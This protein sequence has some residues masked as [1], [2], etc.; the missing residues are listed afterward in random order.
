MSD[1]SDLFP[2]GPWTGFYQHGG[3]RYRQDL[4]LTFENGGL[5]GI[6]SDIVG[7][8]VVRGR[9]CRESLEVT[10]TKTYLGAHSV[11][12]R[13]FREG[14]GI[15]GTWTIA[16]YDSSGFHIW[17]G[18]QDGAIATETAAE[19]CTEAAAPAQVGSKALQTGRVC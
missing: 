14:R 16:R 19:T 10:W 11:E 9:Y 12:Y 4:N 8:F 3:W 5:R 15:W 6:G 18:T 17:P 13:G 2:N 7:N 1:D